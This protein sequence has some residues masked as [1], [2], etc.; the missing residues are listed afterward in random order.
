VFERPPSV[1]APPVI[2]LENVRHLL[3]HDQ[4]R[5]YRVIHRR[6]LAS[7]YRVSRAVVNAAVWVPQN[8][9]RVVIVG[10]RRDLFALPF[11]FPSPGDEREGPGLD[12][13]IL[14]P[15]TADLERY[16]ITPGVWLALQRHR[17]RHE[18][19]GAGFGYGIA[20]VGRPTRTLSARYYKDGAEILIDLGDGGPPRRLTPRECARLMGFTREHLGFEFEIPATL[21]DVQAYKQF[22]NSVVVPQFAWVG[23]EIVRQAVDVFAQRRDPELVA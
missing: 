8:R 13:T 12:G 11:V 16:R 17:A 21:S 7:G 19:Q 2:L 6:L 23:R 20:Q 10:V 3:T 14:E 5:T 9:R 18:R 22:G 15:P 1:G 4:G